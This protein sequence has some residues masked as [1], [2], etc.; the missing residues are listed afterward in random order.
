MTTMIGAES[1]R[2]A[3]RVGRHRSTRP[4]TLNL[5]DLENLVGGEV[6]A[7]R[8]REV[9]AQFVNIVDTRFDD[10]STVAVSGRHAAAAFF[11]LPT[12]IQRVIGANRPD[13]ADLALID[14]VEITWAAANFG[15][16]VIASGDHIFAPIARKFRDAGLGVIQVL[17]AGACSAELYRQCTEHRYLPR[18]PK[19]RIA[20]HN[21]IAC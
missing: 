13:G 21:A 1:Q 19:P 3:G 16:V 14:S 11:A 18:A 10:H 20:H 12:G 6:R 8:V 15:Q 4:R 7:P 2:G 5:I 17:G 9:W